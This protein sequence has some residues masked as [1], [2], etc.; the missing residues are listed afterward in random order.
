VIAALKHLLHG[1]RWYERVGGLPTSERPGLL[2]MLAASGASG[3]ISANYLP[4]GDDVGLLVTLGCAD[5]RVLG[6]FCDEVDAVD[7]AVEWRPIRATSPLL[8]DTTGRVAL[9]EATRRLADAEEAIAAGRK[10]TGVT[11][12]LVLE[13][14][15]HAAAGVD[16]PTAAS[17]RA[18]GFLAAAYERMTGGPAPFL[19]SK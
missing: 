7:L 14:L 12:V 5:Q 13:R 15:G 16:P 19:P 6:E 17:L 4:L 9:R 18:S 1:R 11:A 8:R 3:R 2:V 10:P